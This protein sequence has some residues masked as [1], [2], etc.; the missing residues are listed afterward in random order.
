M[1][2][3]AFPL[4]VL[5]RF[6]LAST[7]LLT[8]A[9]GFALA[10][11]PPEAT[12]L[13]NQACLASLADRQ[14]EAL[15][16]FQQA[17][18]A[19][20]DDFRFALADSELSSLTQSPAFSSLW[21]AHQSRLS[22][23]SAER[24]ENLSSGVWTSPL[25]LDTPD[26]Q[27][28]EVRLKWEDR[29]LQYE[30]TL[31]GK[32]AEAFAP[33]APPPW[34]GGPSIFITL[35]IPDGTSPFESANCFHFS[36]G[37]NKTA[38]TGAIFL[39]HQHGWQGVDELA[40]EISVQDHGTRVVVNGALPWQSI[41][42]FHPLVDPVLGL[43]MA[44]VTKDNLSSPAVLFPDPRAA[45]PAA[46]Y[47]RFIPLSFAAS[48]STRE[49]L[50][51]KL[52]RSILTEDLLHCEM[53]VV[54]DQAGTAH[55]KIDF[56]DVDGHS[57]RPDSAR[58]TPVELTAGVNHLNRVAN[59]HDLRPGPYLVKLELALPSSN[60]LVW[61]SQ[62]LNLG[63]SWQTS[64]QDQISRLAAADQPTARFYLDTIAQTIAHHPERRHPGSL[65][66]TFLDLEALLRSGLASGSIL[67]ETG[68]FMLV[69]SGADGNLKYCQLYL[70]EGYRQ[71]KQ[72]DPVVLWSNAQGQES[73]LAGRIGK[74]IEEGKK[75]QN[76]APEPGVGFPVYLVP[77]RGAFPTVSAETD[78]LES[79]L[80]WVRGYFRAPKVT[81]AAMDSAV[82]AAL[83]AVQREPDQ[84]SRLM[85]FAGANTNGLELTSAL[86]K[87]PANAP[88]I[89]WLDFYRETAATGKAKLLL[90][91]LKKGGYTVESVQKVNG[92]LSWSQVSDRLVLWVEKK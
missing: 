75:A 9:R 59:F 90:S 51:G 48:T 54:S 74:F 15:S 16:L 85:V 41:L 60:H 68:T 50:V 18:Q 49:S 82:G 25:P 12:Q 47:H 2:A 37:K 32:L 80:E 29:A 24:G 28:G 43:N 39:D 62:I 23:L 65:V 72:L 3:T 61:S 20:F 73:R 55:L 71:A 89:T 40:P 57:V 19:G 21:V 88:V 10:T 13:Y 34:A 77:Q 17:Q 11:V 46:Q 92:G 5:S 58:F 4:R 7:L 79:F 36:L 86:R 69:W 70:P 1:G 27:G 64:L 26:G 8:I 87:A 66:K 33:S 30:I 42:P 67:P 6:F 45:S 35:A 31:R 83:L 22:L 52:N 56:L 78:E 14:T 76:F 44:V 38:G 81:L 63:P 91:D 53:T 84:I